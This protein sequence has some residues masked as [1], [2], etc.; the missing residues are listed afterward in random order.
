MYFSTPLDGLMFEKDNFLKE[1]ASAI[2]CL[3]L[4]L[5]GETND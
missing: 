2:A 3:L 4:S 5:A 1:A